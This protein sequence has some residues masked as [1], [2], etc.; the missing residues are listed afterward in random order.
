MQKSNRGERGSRT[1]A[2]GEQGNSVVRDKVEEK[3]A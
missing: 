3:S 1:K 2:E